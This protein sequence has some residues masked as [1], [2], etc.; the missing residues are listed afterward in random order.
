MSGFHLTEA[1]ERDLYDARLICQLV[2]DL[3]TAITAKEMQIDPAALMA[4][5]AVLESK[6]PT[7][8]ALSYQVQ[9]KE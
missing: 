6:L 4:L 3:S 2:I 1:Q 5:C 9:S 8:Q 7:S